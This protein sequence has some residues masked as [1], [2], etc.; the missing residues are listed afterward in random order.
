M[1][2][3]LLL[4]GILWL[5]PALAQGSQAKCEAVQSSIHLENTTIFQVDY[6]PAPA[7]VSIPGSC[8]T[9]AQVPTGSAPL[10]RV[11]FF[12]NTTATSSVHMEAWLPDTWFGRFMGTGNGGIGGCIDYTAL[13][14]GT[15]LHFATLGHDNGHDGNNGIVFLNHPE[16]INDF[17]FRAV[18]TEAVIGKQLVQAYYGSKI[19]KSYYLGCSTGGRQGTQEAL[20]FPGDFDG[21]LGG[22]PATDWNHLQGWSGF[23]SHF[24]GSPNFMG[25]PKFLQPADWATVSAFILAECDGLDG[26]MDGIITE[27]DDCHFDANKLLCKAGQTSGCLTATQVQAVKNVFTPMFGTHG[28]LLYPRYTPGA[29]ADPARAALMGGPFFTFA[30]DWEMFTTLNVT[31]HDFT[32]FSLVDVDLMERVNAG[33]IKTFSGDLFKF[34]E[35]GGKFITYHGR[36]DPLIASTNSKR[37]YDLIRATMLMPTLDPFYRLFLIPGMG[38]CGG[39][40]GAPAFGQGT[41]PT[42][43]AVNASSHNALLALVDW[44]EKGKAPDTIIGT[45]I[46]GSGAER[47]HCRYPQRS[48]LVAGKF[49]CVL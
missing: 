44:V 48:V 47:V 1:L 4:S 39:G 20:K 24:V 5:R 9:T 43:N 7:T 35:L 29:E 26:V 37:V 17:A 16:V 42:S 19:G 32:N 33:G 13:G 41:S 45:A 49:T 28:E 10:C 2:R 6:I 46:D 23:L 14:Y 34:K 18:H 8:G 38:H 31:S 22:A 12:V 36:R 25:N 40:L 30:H 27:P 11:Q 15:S 3:L 21:I